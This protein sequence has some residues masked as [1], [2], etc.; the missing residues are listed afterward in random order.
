MLLRYA[1][2]TPLDAVTI[3]RRHA[4]LMLLLRCFACCF[5]TYA[6]A[7]H[8]SCA[9]RY[10]MRLARGML[11]RAVAKRRGARLYAAAAYDVT[12]PFAAVT[13]RYVMAARYIDVYCRCRL[14][15]L[16]VFTL[17]RASFTV[18]PL[19]CYAY[20]IR[21]VGVTPLRRCRRSLLSLS[22]A[23]PPRY[24]DIS[25]MMRAMSLLLPTTPPMP[26]HTLLLH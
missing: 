9:A 13:L 23:M 1:D 25:L 11:M 16:L 3:W 2:I 22:P 8:A 14:L 19:R 7:R 12:P 17:R 24:K 4:G 20:N 21:V 5:D 6:G 18:A 26:C 15:S 10:G